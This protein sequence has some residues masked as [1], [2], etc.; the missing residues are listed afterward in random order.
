MSS[1]MN[2]IYDIITLSENLM[3]KDM[4]YLS[5]MERDNIIGNCC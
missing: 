2:H 1:K 5:L 4:K 3:S